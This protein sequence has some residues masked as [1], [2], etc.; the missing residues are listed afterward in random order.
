[1]IMANIYWCFEKYDDSGLFVIARTRGQAKRIFADEIGEHFLD[2]RCHIYRKNI[3][4][5][6]CI[7]QPENTECLNRYNLEYADEEPPD[8]WGY[9]CVM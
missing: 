8:N 7:I 9:E 4:D 5:R 3:L 1:M 6:T 2:I